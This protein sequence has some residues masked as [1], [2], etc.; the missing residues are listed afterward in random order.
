M[1][2]GPPPRRQF[3][4][5]KRE[6]KAMRSIIEQ[7][8]WLDGLEIGPLDPSGI[9]EVVG[10]LSRGMLDNPVHVAAFGD[11]PEIRQQKLGT[12]MSAAFRLRD[13]SHTIV[14]RDEEGSIVGVCGMMTPG[15]C[16]PNLGQQVLLLP[17]LLR[18]GPRSAGRVMR[19]LGAWEKRDPGERHWHLGPLAVDAHLQGMGVGGRLMQVFCAQMDAARGDAYLETDKEFNVRFYERFGFDV[20][21]EENVLG[22]QNYFMRRSGAR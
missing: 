10:V 21:G 14:A 1:A 7:R 5:A 16:R 4:Q 6:E 17:T 15:G 2:E 12:L 11:D 3:R 18:L 13:L 22:V 8:E 9:E 19:W 20:I